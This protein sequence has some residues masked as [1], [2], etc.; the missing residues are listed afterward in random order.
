MAGWPRGTH[1]TDARPH[2]PS[3]VAP[4]MIQLITQYGLVLVFANVLAERIGLPLP[5]TPT[6]I[7]AGAL[8]ATGMLFAP[9]LFGA[10]F[11]AC[12]IGDTSWYIAGRLYGRRVMK[13]LCRL[14]LSPDSC[15][16]QTEN[17]F[18][19][20]GDLALVLAKFVPGLSVVARPLAGAMR[21]GW[22][23]FLFLN[24]LG[25]ALWAAA[26][27]A[28]GM[29]FHAQIS[30]LLLRLE[31]L[32][33]MALEVIGALLGAYIAVK[34]WQRRRFYRMLRMARISADELRQLMDAGR[35]PVVVDVRSP[36]AL[37]QDS[38]LIPGA[39]TMGVAEVD[40]RLDELPT[41]R[42]II[43]YCSCPNEASA[44]HVAK[45]LIDLGY[46]RVRPLQGGLDAWIAAGYGVEHRPSRLPPSRAS[47]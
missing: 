2:S 6:L 26:A 36:V 24:G 43:F 29:L 8:A 15:V 39:L 28:V 1:E 5:A 13:L 35:S 25:A 19:R 16:R 12:M 42:E 22:P 14:S 18:E 37:E 21:L 7:I 27:I 38:R 11:V 34:W 9:A 4:Q 17:R 30:R 40:T 32:G 31:D 20:W 45:K 3:S 23:S 41:D 10:A 47:E 44:A 46:T 33:T